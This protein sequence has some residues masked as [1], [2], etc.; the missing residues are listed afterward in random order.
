MKPMRKRSARLLTGLFAITA[1]LSWSEIDHSSGHAVLSSEPDREQ[2]RQV[3]VPEYVT[4]QEVQRVCRELG[5]RDWIQLKG[6]DVS[7]SE[8]KTILSQL[9]AA[10]LNVDVADFLSGLNVELEHGRK[11]KTTDVTKNHPLLTGKIVL[12]HL[13]EFA[14]YYKRLEV[15]EIEGDLHQAALAGESEKMVALQRK[16]TEAR[17]ELRQSEAAELSAR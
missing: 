1:L 10:G 16:L 15:M 12:A 11:F 13:K 14:D 9:E 3:Q 4:T 17:L 5:I 8:A 2:G 6:G 7:E